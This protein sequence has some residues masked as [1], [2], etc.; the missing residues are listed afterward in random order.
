MCRV[1]RPPCRRRQRMP[2]SQCGH[3]CPPAQDRGCGP[4]LPSLVSVFPIALTCHSSLTLFSPT[5]AWPQRDEVC[6]TTPC[7]IS[8]RHRAS[9]IT[10]L[11]SQLTRND[12]QPQ[13][14]V[15]AAPTPSLS[16]FARARWDAPDPAN[17]AKRTPQDGERVLSGGSHSPLMHG[18]SSESRGT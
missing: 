5:H 3:S 2:S 4:P 6:I 17:T 14:A 10:Q 11:V 1:S 8:A 16:P 7:T 12:R 13:A 18:D 9:L 15:L